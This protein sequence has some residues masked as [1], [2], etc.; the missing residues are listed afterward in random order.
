M[1]HFVALSAAAVALAF[2][3][4]GQ[5]QSNAQAA[6]ALDSVETANIGLVKLTGQQVE[7]LTDDDK[8][9]ITLSGAFRH[10]GYDGK[11]I[12]FSLDGVPV[13]ML[14]SQFPKEIP[15]NGTKMTATGCTADG[16]GGYTCT[17]LS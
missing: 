13:R 7:S 14:E 11:Y 10:Y 2:T 17:G 12:Y 9:P 15:P 8:D 1:K 6:P 16:D 4:C 3:L 5:A